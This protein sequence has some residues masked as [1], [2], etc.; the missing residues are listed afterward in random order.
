MLSCDSAQA[1]ATTFNQ[2][3]HSMQS[4]YIMLTSQEDINDNK[5]RSKSKQQQNK[6]LK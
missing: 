4:K 1:T 6:S 5:S 2:A 3:S